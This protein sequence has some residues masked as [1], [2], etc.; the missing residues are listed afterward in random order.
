MSG[1]GSGASLLEVGITLG[2]GYSPQ[3]GGREGG[4]SVLLYRYKSRS[5]EVKQPPQLGPQLTSPD[6][7]SSHTFS[8]TLEDDLGT[9]GDREDSPAASL[10]LP[11]PRAWNLIQRPA[12]PRPWRRRGIGLNGCPSPH[13]AASRCLHLPP[14]RHQLKGES[15]LPH[16]R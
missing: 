7:E 4:P 15:A 6:S 1:G 10:C 8:T 2:H 14:L 16:R 9:R 5:S 3:P 12:P 11:R 13:Q